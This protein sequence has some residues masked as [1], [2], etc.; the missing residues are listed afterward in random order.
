MTTNSF[1]ICGEEMQPIGVGIYLGLVQKLRIK[2]RLSKL[3]YMGA[4]RFRLEFIK[5]LERFKF[6]LIFSGRPC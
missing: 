4:S 3:S 6:C 2:F 5:Y 1:T